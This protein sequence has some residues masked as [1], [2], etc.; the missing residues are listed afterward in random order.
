[1]SRSR[2]LHAIAL[3]VAMSSVLAVIAGGDSNALGPVRA[4]TPTEVQGLVG[5]QSTGASPVVS[6]R[7]EAI[8]VQW[9]T[10]G[11]PGV[12]GVALTQAD[13]IGAEPPIAGSVIGVSGNGC[14]AVWAADTGDGYGQL[15]RLDRCR[16]IGPTQIEWNLGVFRLDLISQ[17][18]VSYDGRFVAVQLVGQSR[19]VFRVDAETGDTIMMP[20][21]GSTAAELG[22]DI[23][24]DGNTVAVSVFGATIIGL[25]QAAPRF[26]IIAWDVATMA[27][28]DASSI[29]PGA[30]TAVAAYPSVSGD[31]RFVSFASSERASS[32]SASLLGPWV[33]VRDRSDGSTTLVSGAANVSY[34]S[35]LSSDGSQ[36]AFGVDAQP[37]QPISL[38]SPG[39]CLPE[40]IDV[41]WTPAPGFESGFQ[42]E[43]VSLT[44]N[45]AQT[46][47]HSQPALSGNGRW[48]AWVSNVGD[49]LLGRNESLDRFDH[50]FTRQRDA[51]LTIDPLDF[52]SRALNTLTTLTTTVRNTGRT[53]ISVDSISPSP[54][55]FTFQPGGS[56][57]IG[58]ALPP[59]GT[60][61]LRIQFATGATTTTVNGSVI[62]TEVGYDPISGIGSLIGRST[63]GPTIPPA[64]T[65][66][67]TA[68]PG[69]GTP[70]PTTT[71]TTTIP[72]NLFLDATPNPIDF[73]QV[74]IGI[75][76]APKTITVTNTGSAS[77]QLF[78]SIFG[79]HPDDFEIVGSTCEEVILAPAATCTVDIR[80]NA[81]DG[82]DRTAL[83][84][85]TTTVGTVEV[86][87]RG[88]G[89]FS[90][91]LAASPQAVTDRSIS[92]I[93]G[94]GFPPDD[95][96]LVQIVGT[97][98]SFNVTPDAE[99][100]LRIPFSPLG[101]LSLGSYTLR[102]D[103]L[104]TVYELIETPLVIVLPTFK[105]QG[106]TGPAFG[107][108]LLVTRGG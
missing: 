54:G 68:P 62:I 43:I 28:S 92:T 59:G 67:T 83:A 46:G 40:R 69:S 25:A 82:G 89:R 107:T 99:G 33:Y 12:S 66:T 8:A 52:G 24:D 5:N 76:T 36:V 77:G 18:A 108:S 58:L 6:G 29:G 51:A 42:T 53:T 87:L 23:S 100:K 79:D 93:I 75:P 15:F 63:T 10:F 85:V 65:T 4:V 106:P 70:R 48:I 91:R 47:T 61:T 45:G 103:A 49:Q 86:V 34:F 80:M 13:T 56:C 26:A 22:I 9:S 78:V 74:A 72:K 105:P 90:P 55:A 98:V 2:R 31:G 14:V 1:M 94:Q 3:V 17:P 60:C 101:K 27:I 57:S 96:V 71:T 97:P 44:A 35:S 73:G 32:I 50:V 20:F 16:G 38:A 64:A 21:G 7:G 11:D 30:T 39:R 102:V 37:C 19:Q 88:Q 41:A 81:R 95:P 84:T 104:P